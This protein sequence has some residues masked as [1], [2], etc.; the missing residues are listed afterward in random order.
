MHNYLRATQIDIE[1]NTT[2]R[3]RERGRGRIKS[4]IKSKHKEHE[5]F[6]SRGLTPENICPCWGV[7]YGRS[8]ST[9][10]L[11]QT[12]TET[13][14]G[15]FSFPEDTKSHKDLHTK[16]WSLLLTCYNL[17][18]RLG[19]RNRLKNNYKI[20]NNRRTQGTKSLTQID[21]IWHLCGFECLEDDEI[22]VWVFSVAL[23]S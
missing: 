13:D 7:H 10:S 18:M 19:M 20:C 4:Q 2:N 6:V 12:I 23:V 3:T 22:N 1:S 9:V 15:F 17:R 11:S 8:S 14:Q 16:N 5:R 21:R